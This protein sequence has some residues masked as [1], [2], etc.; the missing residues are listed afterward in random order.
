MTDHQA[1]GLPVPCTPFVLAVLAYC[2]IAGRVPW[3]GYPQAG[4]AGP[5]PRRR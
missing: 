1:S 5:P 3:K 2:A 4:R